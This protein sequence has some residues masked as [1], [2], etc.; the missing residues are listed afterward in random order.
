[1][2]RSRNSEIFGRSYW[3]STSSIMKWMRLLNSTSGSL[4]KVCVLRKI[5][6]GDLHCDSRVRFENWWLLVNQDTPPA[7]SE[8]Q[9]LWEVYSTRIVDQSR[10]ERLS[11][12][13]NEIR[14]SFCLVA[15]RKSSSEEET[16]QEAIFRW[17]RALQDSTRRRGA[18]HEKVTQITIRVCIFITHIYSDQRI[19]PF[20]FEVREDTDFL[21][22]SDN[23][24]IETLLPQKNSHRFIRFVDV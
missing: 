17:D 9:T 8:K 15:Y 6:T 18:F 12:D 10:G 3:S 19:I 11:S 4:V 16:L 24:K 22:V 13:Q 2:Y 14:F 21:D 7:G 1:M 5:E 20:H 23:P